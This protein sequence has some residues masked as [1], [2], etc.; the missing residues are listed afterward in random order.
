MLVNKIHP[1]RLT[2]SVVLKGFGSA[3]LSNRH[4]WHPLQTWLR[5]RVMT[6]S[7]GIVFFHSAACVQIGTRGVRKRRDRVV[8]YKFL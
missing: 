6:S 1:H 3:L 4:S 2:S 8:I 5:I 7:K